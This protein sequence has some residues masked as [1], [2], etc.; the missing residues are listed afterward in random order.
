MTSE[1][2]QDTLIVIAGYP[3]E[4]NSM[5]N[6]NAGLKSRFT[7]FFQFPDWTPDDCE[8]FFVSLAS[9]EGFEPGADVLEVLK[10]G[11]S[12]LIQLKGWANGRDVKKIWT[13]SKAQRAE[14]VYDEP[15]LVKKMSAH[16][17]SAAINSIVQARIGK[18]SNFDPDADPLAKLDSLFR[19]D[20]IKSKLQT[21]RKTWDVEKRE[22]NGVPNLGHFVFTGNPG[23]YQMAQ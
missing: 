7:H 22:G 4:I 5:L 17:L 12:R 11:C 18:L 15:E 3:S 10:E 8:S 16:D 6:T 9:K 21:L 23:T 1:S 13:H 2:F 14:R 19:M 20:A